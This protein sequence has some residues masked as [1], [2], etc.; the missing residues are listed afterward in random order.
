MKTLFT[1]TS[2]MLLLLTLTACGE[3]PTQETDSKKDIASETYLDSRVNA[4]DMAQASAKKSNEAVE[5]QN[6]M[7]EKL[8][9]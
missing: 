1:F 7:M 9:K 2:T 8:V 5:K 4:L 6:E 3:K